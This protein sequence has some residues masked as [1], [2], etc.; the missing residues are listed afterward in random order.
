MGEQPCW[1]GP[2]YSNLLHSVVYSALEEKNIQISGVDVHV[3]KVH[4]QLNVNCLCFFFNVP[5][6]LFR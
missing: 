3:F 1:K 2:A 6:D 4:V 5:V